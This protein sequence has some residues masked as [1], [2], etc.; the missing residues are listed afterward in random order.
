MSNKILIIVS[1][2]QNGGAQ[3]VASRI[4]GGMA[5]LGEEVHIMEL[6]H[7]TV[8][9]P[10]SDKVV[11]HK[12]CETEREY[13]SFNQLERQKAIRRTVL[14]IKPDVII[15][16]LDHVCQK[17]MLACIGTRYYK[18]IVTT[19]RNSPYEY[20]GLK[21]YIRDFAIHCSRQLAVQN[22]AQ[23]SYFE[24][25]NMK[26]IAVIPNPINVSSK[27]HFYREKITRVVSV[28]R[29]NPQKNFNVLISAFSSVARKYDL[30]LHIYGQGE[31]EQELSK[32][33]EKNGMQNH[34]FLEGYSD[35]VNAIYK[36]ADMFIMSSDYEGMPNALMEAMAEGLPCISTDC[37]TGPSDLI[38]SGENGIL[39]PVNDEQAIAKAIRSMYDDVPNAVEMGKKAKKRMSTSYSLEKVSKIWINAFKDWSLIENKS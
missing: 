25:Q 21:R 32:L 35:N 33:I 3:R 20:R 12:M 18:R 39:V 36:N 34:I 37:E 2:L 5:D 6:F 7:P 27:E 15:P 8:A 14:S 29:L 1:E 30:E 24:K 22:N 31:C 11:L 28:G 16:F 19:L 10:L 38:K 17:V 4:A 26:R 9:F 23:K 13:R